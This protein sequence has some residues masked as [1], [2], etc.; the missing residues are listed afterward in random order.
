MQATGSGKAEGH[1]DKDKE[2]KFGKHISSRYLIIFRK[3]FH[4]ICIKTFSFIQGVLKM[5]HNI[6]V[7]R[8]YVEFRTKNSNL[9]LVNDNY[10]NKNTG[11]VM[12]I[13]V[14]F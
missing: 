1:A 12:A 8:I 11:I 2:Q 5:A 9:K 6:Y 3:Y 4:F 7:T 14:I 13:L 10:N